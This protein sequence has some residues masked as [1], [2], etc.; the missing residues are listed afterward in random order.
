[1][2]E[3]KE[4]K[5]MEIEHN[6]KAAVENLRKAYWSNETEKVAKHYT[7]AED[8]IISAI[9]HGGYT[10]CKET[11]QGDLISREALI[12]TVEKEEGISWD[13]HGKDDLCVRK[14][15]IDNAPAVE[16]DITNDD[17]QAAMTE[18]YHLGYGLAE[19]KFKKPQGVWECHSDDYMVFY[20]CSK[21]NGYG[22]IR[23]K[24]CK[25]CGAEMRT[26]ENDNG[27]AID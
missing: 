26:K 16:P 21:C 7:E 17:L 27:A 20:T 2:S 15:Y 5:P 10:V 9:C 11:T 22:Y 1:M 24:F 25:H 18:S 12:K 4:Y 19:T 3:F 6:V 13:S 23:D 8:I 14:K